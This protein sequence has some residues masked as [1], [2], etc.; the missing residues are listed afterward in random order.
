[1]DGKSL[2]KFMKEGNIHIAKR[3]RRGVGWGLGWGLT[4]V[5]GTTSSFAFSSYYY[6]PYVSDIP[7]SPFP[8]P[9]FSPVSR[10]TRVSWSSENR[11]GSSSLVGRRHGFA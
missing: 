2:V 9:F 4:G 10:V 5:T 6:Y 8:F 1:M 3:R 7:S 11:L